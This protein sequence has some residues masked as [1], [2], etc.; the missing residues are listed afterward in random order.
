MGSGRGRLAGDWPTTGAISTLLRRPS[1]DGVLATKSERKMLASTYLYS[2]YAWLCLHFVIS[3]K[4]YNL[5]TVW[6][7]SPKL[8]PWPSLSEYDVTLQCP[9]ESLLYGLH[10]C[11]QQDNDTR[12]L[13]CI[14]LLNIYLLT[15]FVFRVLKSTILY[16]VQ[17][18]MLNIFLSFSESELNP[19]VL[20]LY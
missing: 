14:C 15:Y 1:S 11:V 19:L 5:L 20:G 7:D 16:T 6:Q 10:L 2:L 3:N 18:Q 9:A 8:R 12:L 17:L 13:Y 4:R